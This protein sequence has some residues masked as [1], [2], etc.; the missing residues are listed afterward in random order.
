MNRGIARCIVAP[1]LALAPSVLAAQVPVNDSAIQV[2]PIVVTAERQ[3]LPATAVSGSVTV[4]QGDALRQRGVRSV[5]DALREVP[6]ATVV[7][8]GSFG[9]QTS[10]FLRGGESDYVK[11]LVDGVPVNQPGGAFDFGALSLDNVERIEVVRGPASVLYGSD[12]VT[13]VVQIFTRHGAGRT[14]GDAAVRAGSFG[15]RREEAAVGAGNARFDWTAALADD[16]TDGV[17][18]FNSAWRNDVVSG[19]LG[20]RLDPETRLRATIRYGRDDYHFPT[21][22]DGTPA[23]S[24]SANFRRTLA[25]T[26]GLDHALAPDAHVVFTGSLSR[27]DDR[28][29]NDRDSP[30]D[31]VGYGFASR[32]EAIVL[33]RALEG[34]LILTPGSR[35]SLTIGSEYLL[36]Q[37]ERRPG[38]AVSNFGFGLDSSATGR[39]FHTRRNIGTSLQLLLQ[40]AD[41]WSLSAGVRLD[42]NEGFGQFVTT[43][44]GVV[45]RFGDAFR[46]RGSIGTGFKTP[47]LEETY[48]NSAFS[49]GDPSLKPERSRSWELGA[50]R[51]F[52][53]DRVTLGA[54]WFD[55]R[56]AQM[57]QYGYVAPGAP[58]YYNVAGALARGLDLTLLLRPVRSLTLEGGYTFLDTKVTDPGFSTGSGDVF[59]K[60]K[61]LIRRPSRAG[62]LGARYVIG[63]RAHVGGM[64][65][66]VGRR[67]DVD[68][69]PFPSV[70][71]SLPGY[72]LVDL[73]ADV[74][75]LGSAA[76]ARSRLAL[77]LR[78][79]NAFDERYQ[80]VVGF[81]GRGR[82]VLGGMRVHW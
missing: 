44:A 25:L 16:R 15:T 22:S 69:G 53:D 27:E 31:T 66:H 29:T 5:A 1:V 3:P 6:G 42:D 19:G 35:W 78:I 41:P 72:A 47:T 80:T 58:T 67:T 34:R 9:G 12:A 63:G 43:R 81:Q 54:V 61:E 49:V 21:L 39:T 7:S 32:D 51:S 48:G 24:N 71:K 70:R 68:F 57:I 55:Q 77:T 20:L 50:E 40:P 62:H 56:F 2:A 60:G 28:R 59:V 17:Y 26:T 38:Y 18:A 52:A 64:V 65:T 30:A 46:V 11:V 79:E 82:T 10:L 8:T 45:R 14:G 37:E 75:P 74:E 23:D 4:L 33:R 13:G 76:A 73:D 36:D